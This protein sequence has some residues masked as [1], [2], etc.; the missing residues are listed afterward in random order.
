MGDKGTVLIVADDAAGGARLRT[1]L[2]RGGYSVF[3]VARGSEAVAKAHEIR[4]HVVVL[5]GGLPEAA[6][7]EVCRALRSDPLMCGVPALILTDGHDDGDVL[8]GLEAGAD[9]YLAKDSAPELVLARVQRL[10]QYRQ[11]FSHAMLDRQLVQVGRLLAGIIHEIRGP[12]SVI[13]GSAELLKLNHGQGDLDLQW[14]DSILRGTQLLQV[15][16]DHLMAAVR[17][18]PPRIHPVDLGSLV[19][20][21]VEL[22]VK[23]LPPNHRG[24]Q[25]QTQCPTAVPRARADAGRVIQ[26]LI[27]LLINAH[28]AIAGAGTGGLILLRTVPVEDQG[29]PWV[30]IE[31]SDDGPGIREIYLNR[32]F[33]PFFTTKEGGTGYGLYLASE[34]LREQ[35]GRLTARNHPGGGACFTIWLP[36]E[37]GT[38][39][40]APSAGPH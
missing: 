30:T 20:E 22:F 8:R 21:A 39:P 2:T 38:S 15:R 36:G 35:G 27:D 14:I 17:S 23:G 40:P 10:V 18:G 12:L 6:G 31:V 37:P 29:A 19:N 9:D 33:E 34:I 3:E 16:L 4:P 24:V 1:V 32:V 5:D 7:L 13:R 28:Q 11:L 26:V 25:I